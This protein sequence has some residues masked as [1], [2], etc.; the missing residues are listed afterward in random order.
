MNPGIPEI[1]FAIFIALVGLVG[2]TLQAISHA[3]S[4]TKW[5]WSLFIYGASILVLICG[6]ITPPDL[7]STI[8]MAGPLTLVYSLFLKSMVYKKLK[9]KK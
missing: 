1:Y 7:L 5:K 6:F 2:N 4:I 9:L 8:L 3:A